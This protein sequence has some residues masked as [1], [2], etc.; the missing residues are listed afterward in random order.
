M[1]LILPG[2][3]PAI[4]VLAIAFCVY[5]SPKIRKSGAPPIGPA[6]VRSSLK[7]R[8]LF[9]ALRPRA[10]I[11]GT[12][13]LLICCSFIAV[14]QTKRLVVIK[15]DG[16]PNETVDQFVRERDPRTGKSQLPWIEHIFYER[17]TRLSNFYVR[18]ISL[19]APSWS[20]LETGQHLQIKGNVE[21]DRYTLAS[22]NYL[23][24]FPFLLN[25]AR[26]LRVDTQ[27]AEVLDSVGV[28]LFTDAYSYNNRY[29]GFSLYQRGTR[30]ATFGNGIM[31]HF[32]RAPKDLFDEWAMGLA[33]GGT[34]E[35]GMITELTQRLKDPRFHYLSLM[36]QD[37]DHVV[38]HNGDRE[39]KLA[40][41]KQIDNN[42]GRIWTAVEGSPLAPETAFII[43]SDHGINSDE[44]IYSQGYNLVK[45]LGSPEGGGHH[46]GTQRRLLL[47]YSIKGLD[48][49][50]PLITTPT[51]DS[52]YLNGQ[53]ANYPTALIDFDGNERSSVHL[54]DSDLN[55]LQ[56]LLQQIQR[57]DLSTPLVKAACDAFFLVLERRRAQW[58]KSLVAL[59]DELGV[60]RRNIVR[61][62]ELWRLQRK[63]FTKAD[64]ASGRDDE[65]RRIFSQ[66]DRWTETE[67][68]YSQYARAMGSLLALQKGSANLARLNIEEIIPLRSMGEPNSIHQLQNYVVGLSPNGLKMESDGSLGWESSFLRL[69]YFARFHEIT[70]RN[71][72]QA[73][74][75][76]RPVDLVAA[77]LP[78]QLVRQALDE[79]DSLAPDAVWVYAGQD[80]QAIIL[81]RESATGQYSFRYQPVKALRQNAAGQFEFE[82]IPWQADLPLKLFEDPK[83]SFSGT[84]RAAWLSQWHTDVEWLRAIHLT[85][86]SNGLIGLYEELARHPTEALAT[87]RPD[88]SEDERLMRAF[89]RSQREAIE[90][91]LLI[92]ANNHWNFDVSGFNPGGNHGSFFR[93]STHS[94]WMISGGERTGIPRGLVV[95]EPY[96]SL[97]FVPTLLALTGGLRDDMTP[98]P[99]L[100]EK[101]FR[102]FPG[103]VVREIIPASPIPK[104]ADVGATSTSH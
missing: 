94:T 73:Q 56:I 102:R 32:K 28:P 85:Q 16:L 41:M 31:A 10:S 13:T 5:G 80:R 29:P 95:D 93:I 39:T 58:Q 99:A 22:C 38:H 37:Y 104:V 50:V 72:V 67:E 33:L 96:D 88:L 59:N 21:F 57:K 45:F 91:D 23:N 15:L 55:T 89:V 76:N 60:L 82:A 53:S 3:A 78:A 44:Q 26:R 40:I 86:Y 77:R 92:V 6:S 84:D 11:L 83:L 74:V 1:A 46:V 54:R 4:A 9:L 8:I 20:L 100:L 81:A 63:K 36:F 2:V 101:G 64:E 49:F 52:Y 68:D 24:F 18:G 27:G 70:V 48:P 69:D 19:S 66:L 17:G 35:E 61:Q 65:T 62:Q 25:G 47:D 7:F 71:N 79:S 75:A 30:F 12:L 14:A 87:N 97:S 42:L 90:A 51:R 43:I 103:R 98:V 34:V